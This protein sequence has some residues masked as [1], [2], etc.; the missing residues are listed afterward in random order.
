MAKDGEFEED[1]FFNHKLFKFLL[2]QRVKGWFFFEI[3][4]NVI[5]Q[6]PFLFLSS[7]L[8]VDTVTPQ[9]CKFMEGPPWNEWGHLPKLIV[10]CRS[11]DVFQ[12]GQ[13]FYVVHGN[14][15][16]FHDHEIACLGFYELTS[17][18]WSECWAFKKGSGCSDALKQ[19]LPKKYR[20]GSYNY[21]AQSAALMLLEPSCYSHSRS[22][23]APNE[24]T[25]CKR[26]CWLF[27]DYIDRLSR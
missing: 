6:Y 5:L 16:S 26:R 20:T 27:G 4:C 8:S 10:N 14:S 2:I 15:P 12:G 1:K 24:E 11:V 3:L 25:D 22:L 21:E 13:V 19:C 7:Y 23:F 18:S 17:D 9:S